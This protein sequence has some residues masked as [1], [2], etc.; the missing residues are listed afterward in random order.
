MLLKED[1]L[2]DDGEVLLKFDNDASGVLIATQVAAG[3]ENNLKIRI[4]GEKGGIEWAQQEPNTLLVKWLDKPAEILRAGA[5]YTN[6]FKQF[7]NKK[8][9]DAGRPS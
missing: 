2:D 4:Y 3:E 8:L 1:I 9:Q 6:T 5:N 7:R